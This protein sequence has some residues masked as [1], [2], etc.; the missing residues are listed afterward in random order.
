MEVT[1]FDKLWNYNKPD[2]TEKKFREVL[3]STKKEDNVDYYL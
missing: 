1:D 2:E 3:S